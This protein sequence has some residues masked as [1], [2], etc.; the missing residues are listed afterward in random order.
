MRSPLG[1]CMRTTVLTDL[2]NR[3]TCRRTNRNSSF[4]LYAVEV[5]RTDAATAAI[6]QTNDR[7][8]GA[9]AGRDS[10][11]QIRTRPAAPQSATMAAVGKVVRKATVPP[12]ATM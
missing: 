12:V 1:G 7:H 3:D 8:S 4:A 9:S 5:V 10:L 6:K 2:S 11:R